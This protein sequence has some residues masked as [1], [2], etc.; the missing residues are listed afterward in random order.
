MNTMPYSYSIESLRV[1][2]SPT[3]IKGSYAL[4]KSSHKRDQQESSS[5]S[6]LSR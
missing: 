6:S 5:L 3:G 4:K 2:S 1:K